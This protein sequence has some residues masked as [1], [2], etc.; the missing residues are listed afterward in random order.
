MN[1]IP[2]LPTPPRPDS[3]RSAPAG[4][5]RRSGIARSVLRGA[6]VILLDALYAVIFSS[7]GI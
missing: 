2:A 3:A 6:G 7:V 5:S 1:S 4:S